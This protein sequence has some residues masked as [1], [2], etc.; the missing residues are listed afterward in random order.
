[1]KVTTRHI[2]RMR[3]MSAAGRT[4]AEIAAELELGQATV[5]R[6]SREYGLPI[7]RRRQPVDRQTVRNVSRLSR[8]GLSG[9]Q[10]AR[11]LG[12]SPTR[13]RWTARTHAIPLAHGRT[14]RPRRPQTE[15][16][17]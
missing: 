4:V 6:W 5:R 11:R 3:E 2:A 10:I 17:I 12:I 9:P 7:N 14:G 15:G 8:L 13:V 16:A 1:M